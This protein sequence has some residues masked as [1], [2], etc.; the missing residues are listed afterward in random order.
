M[1]ELSN[2]RCAICDQPVSL[3]STEIASDDDGKTVH[4]E[5][6]LRLVSHRGSED[7]EAESAA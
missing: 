5:C 2:I 6:Y 1:N 4:S 3:S 7:M